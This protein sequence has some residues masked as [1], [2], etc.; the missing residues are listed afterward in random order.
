MSGGSAGIVIGLARLLHRWRR[1]R[2]L[3]EGTY[4]AVYAAT[5]RPPA[6]PVIVFPVADNLFKEPEGGCD[7]VVVGEVGLNAVCC[8]ELPDGT[9]IWPTYN[10]VVPT[11]PTIPPPR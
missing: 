6:R 11:G 7:A 9:V 2:L 4:V 3:A 1:G 8:L 10:P 5:S